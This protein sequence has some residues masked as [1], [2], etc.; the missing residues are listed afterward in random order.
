MLRCPT[1]GKEIPDNSVFC[2]Q[3]GAK[4]G[5]TPQPPSAAPSAVS[6]DGKL[7]APKVPA[8]GLVVCAVL[9]AVSTFMP[10]IRFVGHAEGVQNTY[11]LAEMHTFATTITSSGSNEGVGGVFDVFFAIWIVSLALIVIGTCLRLL[12]GKGAVFAILGFVALTL[13]ALLWLALVSTMGDVTEGAPTA[14]ILC[15]VASIAG[16]VFTVLSKPKPTDA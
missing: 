13:T 2:T 16:I 6:S 14:E 7:A 15:I 8:I 3:C 9:A 11:S 10:W 1:C 5:G 4:I 12:K